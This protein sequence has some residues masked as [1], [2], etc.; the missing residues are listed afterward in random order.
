MLGFATTGQRHTDAELPDAAA[1]ASGHEGRRLLG[2]A[3][4]SAH[5]SRSLD[6]IARF[7]PSRSDRLDE[8]VV[9]ALVLVGV[10]L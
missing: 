3:E 1:G 10:A 4:F 7:Q 8:L 2:G 9:V 6:T 5:V